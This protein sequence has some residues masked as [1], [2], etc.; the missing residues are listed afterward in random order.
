M[1]GRKPATERD[2]VGRQERADAARGPVYR[3]GGER[4]IVPENGA[5]L[6]DGPQL[7]SSVLPMLSVA[8][9]DFRWR[10]VEPDGHALETLSADGTTQ[11]VEVAGSYGKRFSSL[12]SG[13]W[14]VDGFHGSDPDSGL[15]HMGARHMRTGDGLWMQPEP[16]LYL[17]MTNGDLRR[18]L[19]YGGVYAGGDPV[20][21]SDLSGFFTDEALGN[22]TE[23]PRVEG[24]PKTTGE[25]VVVALAA[26]P[27][28]ALSLLAPGPEDA[29]AV[30]L[31][32]AFVSR[33]SYRL[34]GRA[35]AAAF[36][37]PNGRNRATN[38]SVAS[39]GAP[40]TPDRRL[41]RT[42]HGDPVPD[43]DLPHT[44]LGRGKD[45]TP[46]AR[47]WEV[48]ENGNLQ[49][50]K[51]IDFGDHGFPEGHPNPHQHKLTPANPD[52]A[53]KGGMHRGDP[54]PLTDD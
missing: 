49:P 25:R 51:D 10:F 44:Q 28:V 39:K 19:Y 35:A 24:A 2:P 1:G 5:V 7:I 22:R 40:Y 36:G 21:R 54:E 33:G 14:P 9:G 34:A 30:G 15:S 20:N 13:T 45:G 27:L 29:V 17:G 4:V 42:K 32:G 53:P 46:Q 47:T 48:G 8:D 50:T 31:V 52:L 11:S 23:N 16:L 43:V 41:P 18:P 38:S 12:S 37:S 6:V 3:F 26:A